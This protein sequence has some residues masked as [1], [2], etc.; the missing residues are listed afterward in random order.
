MALI[1]GD[2]HWLVLFGGGRQCWVSLSLFLTHLP[3]NSS[4]FPH[5]MNDVHLMQEC[6]KWTGEREVSGSINISLFSS[7]PNV[8]PK[9][10]TLSPNVPCSPGLVDVVHRVWGG[11]K[12]TLRKLMADAGWRD[13]SQLLRTLVDYLL[14]SGWFHLGGVHFSQDH[15]PPTHTC[16]IFHD[17]NGPKSI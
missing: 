8:I 2:L 14:Q 12:A 15:W 9:R 7:S 11:L 3:P 16:P 6:T 13:A 17:T 10:H 5:Y 1:G 4:V